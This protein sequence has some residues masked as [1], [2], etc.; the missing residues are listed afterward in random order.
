MR[1]HSYAIAL[2]HLE[3]DYWT[4]AILQTT[5][6]KGVIVDQRLVWGPLWVAES[7]L[8]DH[9]LVAAAELRKL[10]RADQARNLR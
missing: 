4:V 9:L 7:A 5:L 3:T 10:V 8:D 1:T 6:K 2:A